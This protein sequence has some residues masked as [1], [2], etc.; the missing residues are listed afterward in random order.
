MQESSDRYDYGFLSDR[1]DITLR[2]AR[3]QFDRFVEEI[4]IRTADLDALVAQSGLAWGTSDQSLREL[5]QWF[6]V[7]IEPDLAAPLY[8]SPTWSKTVFDLGTTIG[9]AA[10][11]RLPGSHWA[12]YRGGR[13]DIDH[14]TPVVEFRQSSATARWSVHRKIMG[15]A[16]RVLEDKGAMLTYGKVGVRDTV[17]DVDRAMRTHRGTTERDTDYFVRSVRLGV[18]LL[19]GSF[20]AARHA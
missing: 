16:V 1:D 3:A 4:P 17:L 6:T 2:A 9:L 20:S 13:T 7:T 18:S 8:L 5:Q 12:L 14:L 15:Y 10:L 11:E 19:D